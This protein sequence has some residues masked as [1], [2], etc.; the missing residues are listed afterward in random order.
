MSTGG[1][2]LKSVFEGWDGY[3]VSLSHA[4]APLTRDQLAFRPSAD[5]RSVG[6]IAA[7]IAFG[8]IDWFVRMG[9]P[10]S[11]E[12]A[13]EAEGVSQEAVAADAAEIVRWLDKTWRMIDATLSGW[14]VDDLATTYRHEYW[15][16]VF[17]ISRQWTIWRIMAHDIQHGGQL[18]VLLGMQGISIPELGDLG[19]HLTEPPSS[20]TAERDTDSL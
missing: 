12:L 10:L 11:A 14:T 17:A 4:V 19:G 9:A 15:G 8:R 2:P 5:A 18:T 3:Q 1:I 16:K 20:R 7:H 6:E 13:A